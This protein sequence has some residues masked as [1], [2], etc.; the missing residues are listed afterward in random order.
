M[1]ESLF[2]KYIWI[3]Y[4]IALF[5]VVRIF[6]LLKPHEII[7]DEAVYLAMGKYLMSFGHIGL[8]E[9]IRPL[10][11][12][13]ILGTIWKVGLPQVYVAEIVEILFSAGAIV[14]TYLIAEEIFDGRVALLA[15]LTMAISPTY[16]SYTGSALSDI[17][18]TFFVLCA[19]FFFIKKKYA[20]TGVF[21]GVS[22][23]TRFPQ[24]LAFG[25]IIM[26]LVF[27]W[28]YDKDTKDLFK[29]ALT[30]TSSFFITVA[31]FF[32]FN[33][34]MYHPDSS[35]IIDAFFRPIILGSWHQSNPFDSV[36][37]F[38]QNLTF[39]PAAAINDNWMLGFVI[40][41]A[42]LIVFSTTAR[43]THRRTIVLFL[44]VY[45]GYFTWIINKQTRFLIVML[46]YFAISAAWGVM[47]LLEWLRKKREM[48]IILST[49]AA[50]V[51]V[52]F[53]LY[54]GT[55]SVREDGKYYEMMS[56]NERPMVAEYY[57]YFASHP[58]PGAILTSDPI[59]AAYVDS[60]FIPFY[61]S[62]EEASE[63]YDDW[64]KKDAV[65]AII[66][67]PSS[68]PC[69]PGD[70]A[71][72]TTRQAFIERVNRNQEVFSK[73]YSGERYSI[74]FPTKSHTGGRVSSFVSHSEL[75]L[76]P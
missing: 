45:L 13:L 5:I 65:S 49:A 21:C 32:I 52:L 40:L 31:P 10:V 50:A 70:G 44:A 43:N 64:S 46:P 1:K 67:S 36:P 73:E 55:L 61:S 38:W 39:Y 4:L 33:Y 69:L 75:S 53:F 66:F 24:G 23:L 57:R 34:F 11:L 26:S 15:A 9:E 17:P 30:I 28:A 18:S 16:F 29:K 68:F 59:P 2:K 12:P 71:C 14:I 47:W 7:W 25:A 56:S 22:F 27:S 62:L 74:Y 48:N 51:I 76:S 19:L 35:S 72:E 42:A 60:L 58:V 6:F 8:F 37:G 63:I 41:G 20:L 54:S 3:G